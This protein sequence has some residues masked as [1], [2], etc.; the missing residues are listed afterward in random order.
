MTRKIN[1]YSVIVLFLYIPAH[2]PA[3]DSVHTCISHPLC[4]LFCSA[5]YSCQHLLLPHFALCRV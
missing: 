4:S 5:D 3:L 1:K 2:A